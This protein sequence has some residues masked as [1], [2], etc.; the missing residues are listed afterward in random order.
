MRV[1]VSY[2]RLKSPAGTE[3]YALTVAEQ[4]ERLGHDAVLV[5]WVEGPMSERARARGLRVLAPEAVGPGTADVIVA[6]DAATLL[7]LAGAVPEAAR[8]MVMH[9]TEQTAQTP[10]Q[11][12]GACQAVV[13]M[14]GRMHR[15]AEALAVSTR[16][17]RLR[18]PVD[19]ERF[20]LLPL[21]R[22][23]LRRAALFGH[24]AGGAYPGAFAAACRS[25]SLEPHAIGLQG[26]AATTE[27][28]RALADVDVVLGIGRCVLEGAAA[29]RPV[30]VAGPA[31]VDGWLRPDMFAELEED[32][33]TGQA[34][35]HASD[36]VATELAA[37]P[38]PAEVQA[39][40]E[41]VTRQHDARLHAQQLVE[42]ARELD[43]PPGPDR[44]AYDE[45][46]RL[47]RSELGARERADAAERRGRARVAQQIYGNGRL[48]RLGRAVRRRGRRAT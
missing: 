48:R 39:I 37:P 16:I 29:R 21:P 43:A 23:P 12:P 41:H 42:L 28:E 20:R 31:G 44:T 24:I 19:L 40:Y 26:G 36:V 13:V 9:S 33:F 8:I 2:L 18:Q 10:P 1:L 7:T 11:L 6:S 35:A 27:P 30:Y 14:N 34:T 45:I 17:A 47:V 22:Y 32:G 25:A 15:R 38:P 5:T 46:S 3:V 4:L